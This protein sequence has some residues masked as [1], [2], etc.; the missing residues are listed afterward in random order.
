MSTTLELPGLEG[1]EASV[2][3]QYA[4]AENF[5]NGHTSKADPLLLRQRYTQAG[6]REVMP[7]VFD[8]GENM[9]AIG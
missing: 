7:G 1:E 2:A 5:R 4:D 9:K 3:P 6:Y 8:D